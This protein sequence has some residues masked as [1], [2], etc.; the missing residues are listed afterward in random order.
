MRGPT[1]KA[2]ALR[3]RRNRVSTQAV[4]PP[5]GSGRRAAPSLPRRGLAR[6]ECASCGESVQPQCPD[7]L[8]ALDIARD[9]HPL[10]R[11]WWREVWH[12]PMEAKFLKVDMHGLYMLA[13][14]V[15]R[16]WWAPSTALSAEIRQHRLAFGLTPIDRRRLQWEIEDDEPAAGRR[17]T[18]SD[19]TPAASGDPRARLRAV[20]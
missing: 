13:E 6:S 18:P 20:K 3:Q 14:L 16:F 19:A 7:C 15:D 11:A 1:P 10:T 8:A 12:S 5:D 4:L 9:W 17:D 2:G